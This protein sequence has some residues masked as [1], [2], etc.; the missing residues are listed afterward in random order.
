MV[1]GVFFFKQAS[2]LNHSCSPNAEISCVGRGLKLIATRGIMKGEEITISYIDRFQ[3]RS[4][5]LKTL[6]E[7]FFFDCLCPSCNSEKDDIYQEFMFK[8]IIDNNVPILDRLNFLSAHP[9]EQLT[10]FTSA[11]TLVSDICTAMSYTENT[12]NLCEAVISLFTLDNHRLRYNIS[13]PR[14]LADICNLL[15]LSFT[16]VKSNNQAVIYSQETRQ[17]LVLLFG[18]DTANALLECT[19]I[20]K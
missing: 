1:A 3:P 12:M 4:F 6:K 14:R 16:L 2:L 13:D 18:P 19:S 10:S 5:R 8:R 17:L 9:Q 7:D 11:L 20:F 15:S